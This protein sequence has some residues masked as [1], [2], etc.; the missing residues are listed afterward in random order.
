MQALAQMLKNLGITDEAPPMLAP[1]DLLKEYFA[2]ET[3]KTSHANEMELAEKKRVETEKLDQSRAQASREQFQKYGPLD[4]FSALYPLLASRPEELERIFPF[5]QRP[6]GQ[7][8]PLTDML[9]DL[10]QPK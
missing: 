4:Q 7:V 1:A 3:A 8:P 9:R 5:Y 10:N 6:E 2:Q